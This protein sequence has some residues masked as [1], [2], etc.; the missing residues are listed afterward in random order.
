MQPSNLVQ[1]KATAVDLSGTPNMSIQACAELELRTGRAFVRTRVRHYSCCT[2]RRHRGLAHP[3]HIVAF[4]YLMDHR[5]WSARMKT[6]SDLG[7]D[8]NDRAT[9]MRT[10][11]R[12]QYSR[13]RS[14]SLECTPLKVLR[15]PRGPHIRAFRPFGAFS[16]FHFHPARPPPP[17]S[18]STS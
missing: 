2:L 7:G 15:H 11:T 17:K 18:M 6:N 3:G 16:F 9:C 8:T 13:H 10:L 5:I 4:V 1:G 12:Y 14:S